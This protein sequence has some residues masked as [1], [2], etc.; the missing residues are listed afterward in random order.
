MGILVPQA[1]LSSGIQLSNVYMSFSGEII[2]ILPRGN[3]QYGILSYCKVWLDKTKNPFNTEIKFPVET[4]LNVNSPAH[5]SLYAE[6]K[7]MFPDST[8]LY[9]DDRQNI[10]MNLQ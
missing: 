3:N 2:Q 7:R 5:Q 9:E 10:F 1:V 8:D 6:L 4:L